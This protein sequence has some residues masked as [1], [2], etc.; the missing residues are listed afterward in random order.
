MNSNIYSFVKN[1]CS[2]YKDFGRWRLK[3]KNLKFAVS[4]K[5]TTIYKVGVTIM[6]EEH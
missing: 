4:K 5:R 3:T 2:V 1:D 6:G